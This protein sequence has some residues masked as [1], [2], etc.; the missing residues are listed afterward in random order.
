[1]ARVAIWLIGAEAKHKF[2]R[3]LHYISEWH[4][5]SDAI[6]LF[7]QTL[8]MAASQ[9]AASLPNRKVQTAPHYDPAANRKCILS[10]VLHSFVP[11]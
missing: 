11:A 8:T 5:S 2:I 6:V 1:M 4:L 9:F 10:K 7:V 3:I